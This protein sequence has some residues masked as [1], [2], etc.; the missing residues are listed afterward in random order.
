MQKSDILN[1]FAVFAV[2]CTPAVAQQILQPPPEAPQTD[3]NGVDVQSLTPSYSKSVVSIGPKGV[4]GL[5]YS[6]MYTGNSARDNQYTINTGYID[7]GGNPTTGVQIGSFS[8]F[9][10]GVGYA[11][12]LHDGASVSWFSPQWYLTQKD[13]TVTAFTHGVLFGPDGMG[14]TYDY[15][16]A[17]VI[18][19]PDGHVINYYYYANRIQSITTNTGYQLK[20]N[21]V[22]N[23]PGNPAFLAIATVVAINNAVEYCDPNAITC[24]LSGSWQQAQFL[25]GFYGGGVVDAN[26]GTT[27]INLTGGGTTRHLYIQTPDHTS[28]NYDF[29]LTFQS[30]S[31]LPLVNTY[32]VTSATIDGKTTSYSLAAGSP[33][34]QQIVTSSA[35]LSQQYSYTADG[36]FGVTKEVD[37]LGRTTNFTYNNAPGQVAS[38]TPPEGNVTNITYDP[39]AFGDVVQITQHPKA[40]SGSTPLTENWTYSWTCYTSQ[41]TCNQPL[42]HTDP[43]GQVTSYT[44]D[45]TTGQVLTETDPADANGINPVKRYAYTVK[46]AYI[47]NASGAYV[48]ESV[49][50]SLLT[51]EKTCRTTATVSGACAG[52]SS[53]EIETDYD[54]GPNSGPNNLLLRGKV[55]TAN[56]TS[57]RAC[58][59]YDNYGNKISETAP[60]AGLTSCP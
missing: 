28:P 17:E 9:F 10:S 52:G 48:A 47:K 33:L 50:I 23:T 38:A 59:G 24:S 53:D 18:T 29:T 31:S 6:I 27:Y 60:R 44:Y 5:D 42:T 58:Y 21:Y 26:G 32:V 1:I 15:N 7:S 14:G 20:F 45:N 16:A 25:T 35:P 2:C 37:P 57:L 40:G 30:N 34:P 12:S 49:G 56:G 36:Y 46:Y 22:S 4:G 54:Y 39:Y 55:V 3:G 8:E 19:H 41:A 13:G 51:S 11:G 43:R